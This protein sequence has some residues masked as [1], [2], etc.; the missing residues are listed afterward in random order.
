[1]LIYITYIRTCENRCNNTYIYINIH[2]MYMYVCMYRDKHNY[3]KMYTYKTRE[4]SLCM[5][6]YVCACIYTCIYIHTLRM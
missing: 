6:V 5:Y 3:L 2:N 4:L 1:M